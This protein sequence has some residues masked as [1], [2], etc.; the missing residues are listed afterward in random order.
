MT[1]DTLEIRFDAITVR[2][3]TYDMIVLREPNVGEML[4]VS[5]LRGINAS[6]DLVALI[7][8]V[9]REVVLKLPISVLRRAN[10][11][12]A[13]FTEAPTPG[14]EQSET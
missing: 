7:S 11:Y 5:S 8:G 3:S 1:E 6:V 2:D 10:D 14:N 13:Q 9:P 4:K 12:L